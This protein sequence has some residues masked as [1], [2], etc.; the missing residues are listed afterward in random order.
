MSVILV[1]DDQATNRELLTTLL[2]YH[3]HTLVEAADGAEGLAVA[4]RERPSLIISD[5]LMPTMDGYEFVRRL[6][7]DPRLAATPVVFYTA[8]YLEGEARALAKRCGVSHVIAKPCELAEVLEVVNSALGVTTKRAAVPQDVANDHLE[9]ITTRLAKTAE[10]LARANAKLEA[11]IDAGQK[12]AT[13]SDPQRLVDQCAAIARQIVG[14]GLCRIGILDNTGA[15]WAHIGAS[16]FADQDVAEIREHWKADAS[17]ARL[18]DCS[19]G[20]FSGGH[21]KIAVS[22]GNRLLGWLYVTGKLGGGPFQEGEEKVAQTL[23][24][25][26]AVAYDNVELYAE[27]RAHAEKLEQTVAEL[28]KSDREKVALLQEVHHRVNNNLAVISSL[29]KM[30]AESYADDQLARALRTTQLRIDAMSQVHQQLQEGADLR[31]VDFADYA[32]NLADHLFLSY[33]VDQDRIALRVDIGSLNLPIDEA[34]PLGLI[35]GELLTNAI[36]YAFPDERQGTIRIEGGRNGDIKLIVRDDGVGVGQKQEPSRRK[37]LGL[38]IVGILCRQLKGTLEQTPPECQSEPGTA[39]R[40][41]FPGK[42]SLAQ[43][44]GRTAGSG[45]SGSKGS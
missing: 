26:L 37:S 13:E 42:A 32:K 23:A 5:V 38:Q 14:A 1:V 12:L 45:E 29:L 43:L 20:H 35:L 31:E 24:S 19:V 10:E 44:N 2:G 40:I 16:G 6:R 4:I 25:Q 8:H 3:G 36:K 17:D 39:F 33:G 9:M 21:L 22:A 11:L 41:S 34:I 15:N 27:A 18:D 7:E 30:Q 28:R